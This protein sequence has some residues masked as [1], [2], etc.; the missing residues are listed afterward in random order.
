MPDAPVFEAHVEGPGLVVVSGEVDVMSAVALRRTLTR[1]LDETT[2]TVEV[3]LSAVQ[4]IDATGVGVLVDV[5]N[6]AAEAGR[7][8]VVTRPSRAVRRIISILGPAWPLETR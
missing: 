5:H 6:K 4:F 8:V 1:A 2:G 3:D 7:A